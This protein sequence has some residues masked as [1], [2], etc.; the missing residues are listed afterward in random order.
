MSERKSG[1]VILGVV[2]TEKAI[3]LM[4][5]QHTLTFWVDKNA[6]K[7]D[8]KRYIEE[9]YGVPV[10]SVKIINTFKENR[11]KAYVRFAPEVNIDSLASRLNLM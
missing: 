5:T 9:T 8:V 7:K 10:Q 6:T 1:M 2:K 4:N 11:K 3:T